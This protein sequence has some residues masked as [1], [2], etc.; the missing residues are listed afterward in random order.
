M[1]KKRDK[2]YR[3]TH[4]EQIKEYAKK[5]NKNYYQIHKELCANRVK[6]WIRENPEKY[7]M[8]YSRHNAKRK[9]LGYVKLN[10]WFIGSHG[11]HVTRDFVVY[12]PKELH[13]SIPHNHETGKGMNEINLLAIK[14]ISPME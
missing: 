14:Y 5:Y 3:E 12:I 13:I 9:E 6:K 7:R 8:L 10:K 2:K 11:H 1:P 4:K